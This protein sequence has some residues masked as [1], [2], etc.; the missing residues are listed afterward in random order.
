M[1][2]GG[3]QNLTKLTTA[4]MEDMEEYYNFGK[5][6]SSY[7]TPWAALAQRM[8]VCLHPDVIMTFEETVEGVFV[9]A[10]AS[11]W[12]NC[13]TLMRGQGGNALHKRHSSSCWYQRHQNSRRGLQLLLLD[14]VGGWGCCTCWLSH[15][16]SP[17]CFVVCISHLKKRVADE[18]APVTFDVIEKKHLAVCHLETFFFF[19]GLRD[20][21]TRYTCNQASIRRLFHHLERFIRL[22]SSAGIPF[23]SVQPVVPS[24]WHQLL[25]VQT[26]RQ[27][28]ACS[29]T[30]VFHGLALHYYWI[31]CS[32][33]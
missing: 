18:K 24:S 16:D 17:T 3:S 31:L 8:R 25:A 27:H 12:K 10:E 1:D 13:R 23:S 4:N 14:V 19:F 29:H 9:S 6:T 15:T 11:V 21:Y 30:L 5:D 33:I 22:D 32:D 7:T 2:N 26:T 20:I 28:G